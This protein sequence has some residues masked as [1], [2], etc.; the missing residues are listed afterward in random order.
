VLEDTQFNI[1][2]ENIQVRVNEDSL[3]G[4][5][6]VYTFTLTGN[7]TVKI[8][9]ETGVENLLKDATINGAIYNLQGIKVLDNASDLNQLPAGMYISNGKKYINK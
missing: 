3:Q 1:I 2:G 4:E 6:G 8:G 5:D 9:S 7:T